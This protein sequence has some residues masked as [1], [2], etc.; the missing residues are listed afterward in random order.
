MNDE[1]NGNQGPKRKFPGS[2]ILVILAGILILLTLYQQSEAK[3]ANVSFSHQFEPLVNLDLINP[4]K[5][6]K[7]A[8]SNDS[9]VTASGEFRE[10]RT[11]ESLRREKFLEYLSKKDDLLIQK[12]RLATELK[13]GKGDVSR[14]AA[15]YLS[16]RG[17]QVGQNG[18][19]IVDQSYDAPDQD[20]AV[21]VH[22][23]NESPAYN[24]VHLKQLYVAYQKEPNQKNTDAL[25][26]N[27]GPFLS[28]MQSSSIGVSAEGLKEQLR[29]AQT[30]YERKNYHGAMEQI[31]DVMVTL[32]KKQNG[33]RV[34]GLRSV[35]KYTDDLKA[36][37]ATVS[38]LAQNEAQLE[39][40][41]QTV[42]HVTW[43]VNGQEYSSSKLEQLDPEVYLAWYAGHK[44]ELKNF[45]ANQGRSFYAVDQKL[46][47]VLE[48]KFKSEEPPAN[49]FSYIFTLL[50]IALIVMLLWFLFSRQSKGVGSSAMTFGKSTARLVNPMKNNVTFKDV[51]GIDEAK[52]EL[53]ELVDFLKNPTRYKAVGAKIPKGCLL[54]GPPGTGKTLLAKAVAGEASRPFFSISGSDFVEMFVGVGASRV[55]DMFDQAKKN[56]PCI[57]FIDEIDAVGRHRGAG[58]GGGHDERE[59]TLNQL[60]VEMDGLDS[61][62]STSGDGCVI[63][64]A[65]TNRVDILDKALLRPGRFDRK[66]MINPPDIQARVKILNVH[67]RKLK[68]AEDVDVEQ[69][70]AKTAGLSGAELANL[71]NEA[72]ILAAR[73]AR[74]IINMLDFLEAADKESHGKQRKS[75]RLTDK[76]KLSTAYH[77]AGHAICSLVLEDDTVEKITIIPRG[78][79]LGA[80]HFVN[81]DNKF[82]YWKKEALVKIVVLMGGR[83]AEEVYCEDFSSGVTGDLQM[84]TGI[85]YDMVCKWG[86]SELGPIEMTPSGSSSPYAQPGSEKSVSDETHRLIDEAVKK[87]LDEGYEKAK[88]IMIEKKAE[89]ELMAEM[90]VEFETLDLEDAK[91]IMDGTWDKNEKHKKLKSGLQSDSSKKQPPPYRGKP[92]QG[93]GDILHAT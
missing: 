7:V 18:V 30:E 79:S 41:Y 37:S 40:H 19:S 1:R 70:A 51:A 59:Q 87:Y 92:M 72:A 42:K 44:T 84:A 82:S 28:A 10:S 15:N 31:H 23:I 8:S 64:I 32:D 56:A 43:F 57:I 55:R 48:K 9:L 39:K 16:L 68:L 17:A 25:N 53:E 89:V 36:Y 78:M 45:Q 63:V 38:D 20:F 34:A 90:L 71:C 35:R 22:S 6:K 2:F 33:T 11:E 81:K 29:S 58:V 91:R 88:A 65:A 5:S 27:M 47:P 50:P 49:Y 60:L 4:E 54:V 24:Y 13:K 46:N 69:I 26:E 61:S 66:V 73:A 93:D 77:E 76:D 86:M 52:E 21:T 85:A 12:E 74:T 80:T 67:T 83:A 75:I 62:H 14:Q 3:T